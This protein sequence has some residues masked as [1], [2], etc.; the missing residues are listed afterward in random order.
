MRVYIVVSGEYSD[1]KIEGVYEW[2]ENAE[3][4]CAAHFD[5]DMAYGRNYEIMAFDTLDGSIRADNKI[6]YVYRYNPKVMYECT[7]P[8]LMFEADFLL[9]SK[10]TEFIFVALYERDDKRAYK[11]AQDENAKRKAEKEGII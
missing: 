8:R 5:G 6:V 10:D 11:I 4:Y 9:A 1:T 3:K 2:L 7:T